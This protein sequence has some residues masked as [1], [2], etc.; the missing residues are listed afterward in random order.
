MQ[1]MLNSGKPYTRS[2]LVQEIVERFGCDA[3]FHTCSAED[4]TAEALVDF[5]DARGKFLHKEGS[6]QTQAD[7]MCSGHDH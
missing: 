5:L 4:L 6:F 7:L 1:M 3:R 2:N